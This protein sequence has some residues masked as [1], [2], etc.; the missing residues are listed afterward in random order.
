MHEA[1]RPNC[2]LNPIQNAAAS[3]ASDRVAPVQR[4]QLAMVGGLVRLLATEATSGT[5]CHHEASFCQNCIHAPQTTVPC[6][7]VPQS[8][9]HTVLCEWNNG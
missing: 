8:V 6:P 2:V 9:T 1:W 7:L 4:H 5:H 3:M